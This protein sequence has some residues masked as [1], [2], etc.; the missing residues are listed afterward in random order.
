MFA[1]H[2][3][4]PSPLHLPGEGL[5]FPHLLAPYFMEAAIIETCLKILKTDVEIKS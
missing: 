5:D 1:L 3:D 4:G 2:P